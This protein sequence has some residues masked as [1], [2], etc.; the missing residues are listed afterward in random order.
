MAEKSII[1]QLNTQECKQQK[2]FCASCVLLSMYSTI[3]TVVHKHA[4]LSMRLQQ[5][6]TTKWVLRLAE[7]DICHLSLVF[8]V[9]VSGHVMMCKDT[10]RENASNSS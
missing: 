2:R 4:Q 3:R 10:C 1:T 7:A 9:Q 6:Q 5:M 8:T